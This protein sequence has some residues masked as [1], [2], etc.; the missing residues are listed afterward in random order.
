MKV[1]ASIGNKVNAKHCSVNG[2]RHALLPSL[3]AHNVMEIRC[4]I[5]DQTGCLLVPV[6]VN[7]LKVFLGVCSHSPFC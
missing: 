1:I 6:Q 7:G 3:S 5:K 4:L 2:L